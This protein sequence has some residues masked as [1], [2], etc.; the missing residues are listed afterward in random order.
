MVG[1]NFECINLSFIQMSNY[2]NLRINLR[3]QWYTRLICSFKGKL[4]TIMPSVIHTEN[5]RVGSLPKWIHYNLWINVFN[6]VVVTGNTHSLTHLT[7]TILIYSIYK[8]NDFYS[9]PK[10]QSIAHILRDIFSYFHKILIV[11]TF[12]NEFHYFIWFNT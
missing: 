12:L 6:R 9:S 5:F 8:M 7:I 4:V 10:S 3:F 11:F 1:V 2:F